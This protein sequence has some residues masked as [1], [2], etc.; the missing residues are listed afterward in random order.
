MTTFKGDLIVAGKFTKAGGKSANY[1]ARWDGSNWFPL[2]QGV[3]DQVYSLCVYN[4]ELYVGGDFT[5]A[6]G[7]SA[8]YIAKWNGIKWDSV[9]SG[10]NDKIRTFE[11][12]KNNL[13]V[14]GNF[15][16]I[17][18]IDANR[19]ALFDGKTWSAINDG[20]NNW[21]ECLKTKGDS[22]IIGGWFNH[23]KDSGPVGIGYYCNIPIG[24]LALKNSDTL[25]VTSD[26]YISGKLT[27]MDNSVIIIDNAVLTVEGDVYLKN[28]SKFFL[29]NNGKFIQKQLYM[30]QYLF[31]MF[32]NS[33][34][35]AGFGSMSGSGTLLSINM[36]Q[37]SKFKANH[38]SF[39]DWTFHRVTNKSSLEM[40]NIDKVGDFT[41][42]D[43]CSVKISNSKI[44]M[45]WLSFYKGASA[46]IRLPSPNFVDH[47]EFPAN[48][49]SV[50]GVYSKLILDSCSTVLWSMIHWS[51]CEVKVKDSWLY[52]CYERMNPT[53]LDTQR[54]SNIRDSITYNYF[55]LP[56]TDRNV[57]FENS[58]IQS[59]EFTAMN[60]EVLYGDS[61]DIFEMWSY[62]N[63]NIYVKN[64][65]FY[66][67]HIGSTNNSSMNLDNCHINVILLAT[68]YS[69]FTIKNSV[70]IPNGNWKE[71]SAA[72]DYSKL[73]CINT[74]F[75]QV[76]QAFDNAIV[77]FAY[78]DSIET[79]NSNKININGSAWTES[80]LLNP[81]KF[82][83]Y[84][85]TMKNVNSQN[86]IEINK[87][88]NSIYDSL[89]TQLVLPNEEG[90][91]NVRLYVWNNSG[92]TAVA[93]RN[94]TLKITDVDEFNTKN[95]VKITPNPS[96]DFINLYGIS[97]NI[98]IFDI[99]GNIVWQGIISENQKIVI[100][101]FH[102]GIY[103]L[104][105]NNSIHK[106]IVIR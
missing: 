7:I 31:Y 5:E 77:V 61:L 99:I 101:K 97:G 33:V 49:D 30:D 3:N 67:T 68:N 8:K 73:F 16:R 79:V 87:S 41:L 46:N 55:K 89:L 86:W 81:S 26:K 70:V 23:A 4:N 88:S 82:G 52:S 28:N 50:K 85:I 42:D 29:K 20:L 38:T 12:Y 27:A 54:I 1:I 9:G 58:S 32:D 78:L 48:N 72:Q 17:G 56:L 64:S 22:L 21:V 69:T 84:R 19:I 37:Y 102:N 15:T 44:V 13:V 65:N 91:Y 59:W 2:G 45:P 14:G 93:E 75:S 98:E 66:G 76:P 94:Y 6:G 90:K 95:T 63:S 74:K 103:F 51:G 10:A 47:F 104:K 53:V 36:Y 34:V 100:T 106:F 80:G 40:S 18:N 92:D 96:S 83:G 105:T 60:N 62:H 39:T 25:L 43:S 24:E 35:D 11:I 57:V 71:V